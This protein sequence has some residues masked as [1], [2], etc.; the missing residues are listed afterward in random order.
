MKATRQKAKRQTRRKY[1]VRKSLQRKAAGI[2]LTVTRSSKH[3][4]AQIVDDCKGQT[5]CG[6][7][8]TAKRFS[9]EL[10]GKTKTECA[11]FL[12]AEIAKLAKEKGVEKVMFDRGSSRYHGRVKALAEAAREGGLQF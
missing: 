3:I 6:L 11:A 8:T 2:R 5:V 9:T 7:T 10:T 12:G 4:S 1:S